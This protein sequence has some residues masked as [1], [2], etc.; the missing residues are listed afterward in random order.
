MINPDI[1]ISNEIELKS[2]LEDKPGRWGQ[3]VAC[4]AAMRV[5]PLVVS[6][7]ASK[8]ISRPDQKRLSIEAFRATHFNWT[9]IK[10]SK[11]KFTPY[12]RSVT[13]PTDPIAVAYA[14]TAANSIDVSEA[15]EYAGKAALSAQSI[16]AATMLTIRSSA[17]RVAQK[18]LWRSVTADAKWLEGDLGSGFDGI[19]ARLLGKRL[20]LEDVREREGFSVNFPPWA[21]TEWDHFKNNKLAIAAGFEIW[22]NWYEARLSG[23]QDGGFSKSLNSESASNLDIY[24]AKED[25]EWWARGADLINRDIEDCVRNGFII[26]KKRKFVRP[27]VAQFIVD[28]LES[29]ESPAH[30]RDIARAFA[31]AEYPVIPKTMRGQLSRLASDGRIR[32]V[33]YGLY[34]ARNGKI[35]DTEPQ[36]SA[37]EL[38]AA[39]DNILSYAD[40]LPTG[41]PVV[42]SGSFFSLGNYWVPDDIDVA[43]RLRS[44]GRCQ[45]AKRK[46]DRLF[47]R[48]EQRLKNYQIW[49]DLIETLPEL[50]EW[51]A[52]PPDE[53]AKRVGVAWELSVTVGRF[54][55]LDKRLHADRSSSHLPLDADLRLS[56][57]DVNGSVGTL[58]R[59]FATGAAMDDRHREWNASQEAIEVARVIFSNVEKTN[60]LLAEYLPLIARALKSDDLLSV[61]GKKSAGWGVGTIKRIGYAS[62]IAATAVAGGFV[63]GAT[64]EVGAEVSRQTQLSD[65]AA[66][67]ILKSK[68]DLIALSKDA[69][70]DIRN[71]VED[72]IRRIEESQK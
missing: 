5:L 20:W 18:Q 66:K 64:G 11:H 68:D 10:N 45:I 33:E 13:A 6:A 29:H 30:V 67:L 38:E 37:V 39:A 9:S 12:W 16:K 52:L 72:L 53:M 42:V 15:I 27:T 55:D 3:V 23:V 25:A 54:V 46:V 63:A 59:E 34:A 40:A 36:A 14:S 22:I 61:Q 41:S 62:L 35:G 24:L 71:A 69:P 26:P 60:V 1:A 49:N 47:E 21:R 57:E 44:V 32:R 4:R 31:I 19:A 2:W 50:S 65:K 8:R 17:S 51:L 56:L 28:Y 43:H 58:L 7:F 70:A 48:S